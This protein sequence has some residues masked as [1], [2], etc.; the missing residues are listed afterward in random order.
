MENPLNERSKYELRPGEGH[1]RL[2]G[3]SQA[4]LITLFSPGG[5]VRPGRYDQP[6]T[7]NIEGVTGIVMAGKLYPEG[8][9]IIQTEG[10]D[11]MGEAVD[12]WLK[13]YFAKIDATRK[14]SENALKNYQ[15]RRRS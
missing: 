12:T 11:D 7:F 10:R 15:T 6:R 9:L 4:D 13:E 3:V 2:N 14:V 1:V 5:L 8:T